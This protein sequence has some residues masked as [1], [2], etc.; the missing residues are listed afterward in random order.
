MA[1]AWRQPPRTWPKP[2][3]ERLDLKHSITAPE[4]RNGQGLPAIRT[5]Q[6]PPVD[7]AQT[8]TEVSLSALTTEPELRDIGRAL[9]ALTR[10]HAARIPSEV[11][12]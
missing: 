10:Y 5:A 11:R 8:L 9:I 6:P 12:P 4:G 7:R 3:E 2:S 1:R